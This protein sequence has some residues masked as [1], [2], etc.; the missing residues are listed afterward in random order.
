MEKAK[1]FAK[2]NAFITLKDHKYD[3][4]NNPKCR[5]INPTKPELGKVSK[6]I[7]KKQNK[8]VREQIKVNQWHNTLAIINCFTKIEDK[9]NGIFIQFDIEECYP[10]ISREL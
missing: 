3:F 4:S 8:I 6:S 7:I 1:C 5:V 10:S 2:S 9:V